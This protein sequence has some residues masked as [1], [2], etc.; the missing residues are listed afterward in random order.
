[1]KKR[2]AFLLAL[3]LALGFAACA[4]NPG[5]K[6]TQPA[7]AETTAA[8]PA[9]TETAVAETSIGELDAAA[10]ETATGETTAPGE[11][12]ALPTDTAGVVAYY[13][14]ALGRTGLRRASFKRTMTK[15]TAW[16]AF[17]L[18]DEQ[19]LQDWRSVQALANVDETKT[20]PSDLVALQPGWV[21]EASASASGGTATLTI[22]LKDHAL[23]AFD[24]KPGAY[25]YVS[26]I[27]K[28]S[29]EQLVIDAS[30]ALTNGILTSAD[31]TK[32]LFGLENGVY[33]VTVDT[34]TGKIKSLRFTAT[35]SADGE[36]KCRA[37]I[38]P[39]PGKAT[40]TL[41]GDMI[42]AYLPI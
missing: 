9:A 31:V 40:I 1:M 3:S 15:V 37:S 27:D 5:P 14:A 34:A 33:T 6:T 36:A 18:V 2:L 21:R 41:R 19:D 22:R 30:I 23:G 42:A 35:Q 8:P 38:V 25:G 26:T 11:P 4:G 29:A 32:A 16:A 28:A 39:V 12:I 24:P 7:A 10:T 20:A 13:N 17:G